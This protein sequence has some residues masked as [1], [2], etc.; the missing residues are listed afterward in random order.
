VRA[1]LADSQTA[2]NFVYGETLGF[3]MSRGVSGNKVYCRQ[4]DW[5][6]GTLSSGSL[7]TR[8][9]SVSKLNLLPFS[10]EG[11]ETPTLL[12]P[13]EGANAIYR[14]NIT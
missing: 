11:A 9:H 1:V 10:D 12:V 3:R 7:G 8:E 13:L 5:S 14:I 2:V 4:H 6:F